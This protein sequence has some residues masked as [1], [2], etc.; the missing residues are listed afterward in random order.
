[1]LD[2]HYENFDQ[3]PDEIVET[4]MM[5][6]EDRKTELRMLAF[7]QGLRHESYYL[8]NKQFESE[9]QHPPK[10]I[11]ENNLK[12]SSLY[13]GDA[14]D[15]DFGIRYHF[16]QIQS[17]GKPN[18]VTMHLINYNTTNDE[19]EPNKIYIPADIYGAFRYVINKEKNISST[20][21]FR[22]RT[23]TTNIK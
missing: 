16:N 13:R 7:N 3:T 15:D 18:P 1:M 22:N 9:Q 10:N 8:I 2:E 5:I 21:A 23:N 20:S 19:E 12:N 4:E 6:R 17:L 14:V 11:E